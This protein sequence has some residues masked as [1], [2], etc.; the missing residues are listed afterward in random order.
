MARIH[1][2]DGGI[3]DLYN[4]V[5]VVTFNGSPEEMGLVG[6]LKLRRILPRPGKVFETRKNNCESFSYNE[7]EI[8]QWQREKCY[9]V[10]CRKGTIKE[11]NTNVTF[12]EYL[13]K[14]VFVQIPIGNDEK[15][16]SLDFYI[17]DEESEENSLG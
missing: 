8:E 2:R 6:S 10:R 12:R 15:S 5:F 7:E 4:E 1:L 9:E 16:I 3:S 11:Q 13:A 17:S 14:F